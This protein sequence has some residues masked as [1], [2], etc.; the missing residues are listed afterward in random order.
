VTTE[1][2]RFYDSLRPGLEAGKYTIKVDH[3]ITG[4]TDAPSPSATQE[5]VVQGPRFALDPGEIH[6]LYPPAHGAGPFAETFPHVVL[7]TRA[8]PW[9]RALDVAVKSAEKPLRVPWLAL[10]LLDAADLPVAVTPSTNGKPTAGP[11]GAKP[12]SVE[13]LLADDPHVA[14]PALVDVSDDELSLP[15]QALELPT[16]L[17]TAVAPKPDEL[18]Y[19]VHVRL[20]DVEDKSDPDAADAGWY[21]VVV[22]NRTPAR[23]STGVAH[24]VSL[25]G[26]E[27]LLAGAETKASVRLVSLASWSFTE[28]SAADGKTPETTSFGAVASGLRQPR[29]DERA[30]LALGLPY[31]AGK[32][33]QSTPDPDGRVA[34]R[35]AAGYV[36]IRYHLP[37]GEDTFAW[38]RGPFAA[39][40]SGAL[41]KKARPFASSSAALVYDP[42][43][44]IFDVSL[45]TAWEIGRA[46]AL[47]DR[48]FATELVRFRRSVHRLVDL[49]LAGLESQ[50]IDTSA[51]NLNQIAKSGLIEERFLSHLQAGLAKDIAKVSKAGKPPAAAQGSA[52]QPQVSPV[53]AVKKLLESGDD[54]DDLIDAEVAD[55]L[56]PIADWLA[57]LT[58]LHLVPFAYLVPHPA[59]LP[60]ESIR[61]FDVDAPW[62]GALF[63]GALSVGVQSSRDTWAQRVARKIIAG[64]WNRNQQARPA[65]GLLL[66]SALVSGW[67]GLTVWADK[68]GTALKLLRSERLAPN[69]LLCLFDD[70]PDQVRL[71]APHQGLHFE[72]EMLDAGDRTW[73]DEAGRVLD[74]GAVAA[75]VKA[76]GA[77]EL[78]LNMI[79]APD[80]LTFRRPK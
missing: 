71:R 34:D 73:R 35:L 75:N 54:L 32:A 10:L 70:I 47:A 33:G 25:E 59:L 39:R 52:P 51:G 27:S 8:L 78:A 21:A 1:T 18:D 60:D 42:A 48:K 44:G 66:R 20:V 64:A 76:S 26:H 22:A 17:I 7:T 63:D 2:V 11:T 72:V 69:V 80:Q 6:A 53:D 24:L 4:V 67:P 28:T 79:S 5:L 3:A 55:D 37:T 30:D 23:A 43:T 31:D 77:A 16:A 12:M 46:L 9:E 15:C 38:Y 50:H 13:Q 14:A 58:C 65:A 61:F 57:E 68:G 74:V 29:P 41:D 56:Q 19:L 36:P 40:R 49:V 45:A 62:L